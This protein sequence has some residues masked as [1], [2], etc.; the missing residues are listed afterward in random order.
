M[1]QTTTKSIIKTT[2]ASEFKCFTYSVLLMTNIS[3]CS[4]VCHHVCPILE[5]HI[6]RRHAIRQGLHRREML[7]AIVEIFIT[8]AFAVEVF[9]LL[10]MHIQVA[11]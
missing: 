11:A 4:L 2:L 8:L 3:L 6:H 5:E 9:D 7:H 10:S 1:I